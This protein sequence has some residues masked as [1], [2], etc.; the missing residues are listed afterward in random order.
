LNPEEESHRKLL[1]HV[2]K[3]PIDKDPPRS[4]SN[5][6]RKVINVS[7]EWDV[8]ASDIRGLFNHLNL[9]ELALQPQY[10]VGWIYWRP[11]SR[12]IRDIFGPGTMSI[13]LLF[14]NERDGVGFDVHAFLAPDGEILASGLM[15]PKGISFLDA[16]RFAPY[17]DS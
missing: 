10:T 3:P 7:M 5:W 16:I 9:A 2:L 15:D 6:S 12:Y 17:S 4:L 13:R 8:S 14:Q 1:N 11:A